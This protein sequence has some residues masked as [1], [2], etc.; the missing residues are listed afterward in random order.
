VLSLFN[1]ISLSVCFWCIGRALAL[2]AGFVDYLT[3][4]PIVN[5][6]AAVPLTPGGA[7]LRE[8]AMSLLLTVAG[9]TAAD[10]TAVSLLGYGVNLTW[11]LV[12]G[13]CYLGLR[14][15]KTQN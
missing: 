1:H 7:G 6:V 13:L 11:A 15:F 12:G 14:K 3:V 10:A 2:S 4:V 8:T 5:A 9:V